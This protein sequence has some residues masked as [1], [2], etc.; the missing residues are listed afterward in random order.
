[1]SNLG[2][3]LIV[4]GIIGIVFLL[5]QGEGIENNGKLLLIFG[6]FIAGGFFINNK[7]WT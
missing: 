4:V 1:M 3:Q 7:L 2:T 5:V 6:A